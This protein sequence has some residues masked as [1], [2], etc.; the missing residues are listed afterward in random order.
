MSTLPE[1]LSGGDKPLFNIGAVSRLTG[2]S[3]A[4]LRAWERRYGFPQSKRT[5]GGHR[6]YSEQDVLKL[7]WVKARIQEGMQTSQAIQ[8]LRHQTQMGHIIQAETVPSIPDISTPVATF[9]P[10]SFV[11]QLYHALT[12]SEEEATHVLASAL[13]L[14]SPEELILHVFAPL[15][16]KV[17]N[18]W[19]QGEINVATEHMATN[20][21]RQR[22]LMWMVSGPPPKP[23]PPIILACAPQEWHEGSLLVLGALLRRRRWPIVYLGQAV[24]LAD[25]A[26]LVNDLTPNLVV[27]VAMTEE[28]AKSLMDIPVHFPHTEGQKAPSIGYGGRVFVEHPQWRARISGLYL[29]DTFEE[30]ILNIERLLLSSRKTAG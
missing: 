6:L 3:M 27:F 24:P 23:V 13:A 19:E 12:S 9:H 16:E 18:A 15:L 29:G 25:L 5:E 10:A 26:S 1:V 22:L 20:F 11:E 14:I 17:G 21:L 4:T 28:A 7:R 8:A 2:L 30:G